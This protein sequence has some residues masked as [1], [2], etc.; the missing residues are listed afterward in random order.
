MNEKSEKWLPI[1][2]F[3]GLYEVS[4]LGRVKSLDKVVVIGNNAKRFFPG[5]IM[6]P[7]PH[8]KGY[9]YV[10]LR[11]NGILKNC[12]VHRLVAE[13]FL[14]NK[15]KYPQVNHINEKKD[16]NRADNL[17]WCS[18]SYNLKYGDRS[19]KAVANTDYKKRTRETNYNTPARI[20]QMQELHDK[21]SQPCYGFKDGV[22]VR[23]K[24]ASEAARYIGGQQVHVREVLIGE[25]KKHKNWTFK[26]AKEVEGHE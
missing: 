14:D 18:A 1:E 13:A 9:I 26:F 2:G 25:R 22:S 11:K 5:R 20:K 3:E 23:F 16:D 6:K 7:N 15:E 19:K 10:P 12:R 24:S 21:Q 17:E 4:D 8:P